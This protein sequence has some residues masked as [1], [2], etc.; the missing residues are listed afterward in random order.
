MTI[1]ML[2]IGTTS[3][4]GRAWISVLSAEQIDDP[5]HPA[6]LKKKELGNQGNFADVVETIARREI[7]GLTT[8]KADRL[9]P[10]RIHAKRQMQLEKILF[11]SLQ[12][13][14]NATPSGMKTLFA[15]FLETIRSKVIGLRA[16]GD[17][18]LKA[19]SIGLALVHS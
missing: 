11:D 2:S 4:V 15:G 14:N 7:K 10:E 9:Y 8:K 5:M 18:M 13:V 12:L 19:F 1:E 6:F 17:V 3:D 16:A